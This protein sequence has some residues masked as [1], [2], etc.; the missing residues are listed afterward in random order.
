MNTLS[1]TVSWLAAH[2]GF[3]FMVLAAATVLLE[4]ARRGWRGKRSAGVSVASG[5][6]FAAAKFVVGKAAYTALALWVWREHRLWDLDMGSPVVWGAVFVARDFVYYWVHRMEHVVRVLWAAHM[7]HHSPERIDWTTAVRVPWMEA[8]YKPWLGL[9]L[10]LVGFHPLAG[11]VLDVAAAAMA[12]LYHTERDWGRGRLARLVGWV[13]V[14]P[15]AHRVHHGSNRE[16][17]DKNFGAV[18]IVWDRMFGTFQP[19]TVPV[20]Y[21]VGKDGL[22]SYRDML[23]G[24]YP[25]LWETARELPTWPQ[26]IRFVAARPGSALPAH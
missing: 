13:F 4:L 23:T 26:R 15:S 5:F 11:I 25:A 1:P 22:Y 17:I 20:R 21:G 6:T 8:L 3:G 10:P 12:Q 9:W 2:A 19:E 16:Y 24:G 18:L 14:T 7:V